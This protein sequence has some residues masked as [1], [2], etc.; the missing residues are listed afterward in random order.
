MARKI[1][2]AHLSAL[3]LTLIMLLALFSL[4]PPA[5]QAA[6]YTADGATSFTFSD[7][8]ITVA[9]GDYSGYKIEDTALTITDAGTYLVSGS[10]TDGSITVKKGSTGVIL[11][12]NG[13]TLTSGDTAPICCN[14]STDVT[15]V[16]AADTT[17]TLTDSTEN[18]GENY[19]DNEN[20]ENAV[21]K[22]KDGSNVII[23]GSG[24]LNIS[25]NG[26]NGIK[27]GAATDADGVASLTIQDVKLNIT[28]PGNDAINAEQLLNIES[29][30]LNIT[31][32][33]DAI[34]CDY[35]LNIGAA[36]TSGPDITVTDCYEAIEAAAL[37]IRSGNIDITS[38]DDCLNA[39]NADLTNYAFSITISGGTIHAYSSDGDGFDSNGSLT[40]SGGNV[41]VWTANTAD[42]QP[43]DADG[44][45]T[46]SGATLLAAG[47]SAGIGTKL[48]ASQ[49]YVIFGAESG[50]WGGMNRDPHSSISASVS[51][52]SSLSIKNTS[53]S[54][55]CSAAAPC[56]VNYVLFSSDELTSGSSYT[57]YSDN[58]SA[59]T[60]A[61][62]EGNFSGNG[63]RVP[64]AA[65]N[66]DRGA[67]MPTV[68]S[69]D[70]IPPAPDRNQ[71]NDRPNAIVPP[72]KPQE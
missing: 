57:L 1:G 36:E 8:G 2:K 41:T 40:I 71:P 63:D 47:G 42:N 60:A 68:E 19:A 70:V 54:I 26:K 45:I 15:I 29:G 55:M 23:C 30:T 25:A 10:C 56:N 66:R 18:N 64:D 17:N 38:T 13:L 12:L 28:A 67:P 22:C 53:G 51:K 7:S 16:V 62:Q 61:A 14:K 34:H 39:S 21:I 31:A 24:T 11:V 58:T 37:N 72:E 4:T 20:V 59:A 46:I 44:T 9:E 32:A 33:D 50:M 52:G 49:P 5:A 48:S 27:S 43:L 35:E 3:V 6:D 65:G 69:S